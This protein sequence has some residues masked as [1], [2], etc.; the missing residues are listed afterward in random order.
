MLCA[1][2]SAWLCVAGCV[3]CSAGVRGQ[4]APLVGRPA[5]LCG[6]HGRGLVVLSA[7][8][9]EDGADERTRAPFRNLFRLSP[10]MVAAV[11]REEREP[12]SAAT[13]QGEMAP[14]GCHGSRETSS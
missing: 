14:P 12:E 13:C 8:H 5:L 11:S 1:L 6:L 10:E 2:F 9:L 7:P 3:L 4:H